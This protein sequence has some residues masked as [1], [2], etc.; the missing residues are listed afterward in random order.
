M[1]RLGGSIDKEQPVQLGVDRQ[2]LGRGWDLVNFEP[3][4]YLFSQS[5]KQQKPHPIDHTLVIFLL[6][7]LQWTNLGLHFP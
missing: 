7:P 4:L 1:E 2:G 3:S 6:F 5:S